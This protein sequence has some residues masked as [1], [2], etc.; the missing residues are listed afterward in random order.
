MM[1]DP[2]KDKKLQNAVNVYLSENDLKLND[3]AEYEAGIDFVSIEIE[4]VPVLEVNLPPVSNY[5]VQETEYTDKY[6]RNKVSATG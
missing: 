6:L 3:N 5:L 1:W 2:K 4:G